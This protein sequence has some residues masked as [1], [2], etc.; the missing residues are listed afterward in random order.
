MARKNRVVLR[1]AVYHVTSHV[2]NDARLLASDEFKERI[3][4]WIYGV[5]AFSG[6]EVYAWSIQDSALH[7]VVRAPSVPREYWTDSAI[8]PASY[9]FGMRPAENRVQR[10]S[11]NGD[12]PQPPPLRPVLGFM[13]DDEQMLS[14]LNSLYG[15]S[16][17]TERTRKEWRRLR[18]D[19]MGWM[20]D[21]EKEKYAR[22]MYNLSQFTK[23]LKERIAMVYN[24]ERRREGSFWR[25]RFHSQLL[26]DDAKVR[27]LVAAFGD[28]AAVRAKAASS[29]SEYA[30]CSFGRAGMGVEHSEACRHGYERLLGC[31]WAS[32]KAKMEAVFA[33]RPRNSGSLDDLPDDGVVGV[34]DALRGSPAAFTKS[35]YVGC[36]REK[37]KAMFSELPKDFPCA[38]WRRALR[39]WGRLDW[40]AVA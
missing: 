22:R 9:A 16:E 7:L 5:A 24:R 31:D 2:V 35:V 1:D 36:D 29:P 28:L 14:R 30:W 12:R 18:G 21:A 6:V 39:V 25:G 37:A 10:W 11:P 40:S 4:G 26:E 38:S 32:A 15:S 23:T 34:A 8:D 33:L 27:A 17:R 3:A 19:G 20:V 13:L